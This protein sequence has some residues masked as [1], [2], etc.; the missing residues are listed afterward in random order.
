MLDELVKC[1]GVTVHVSFREFDELLGDEHGC[2]WHIGHRAPD[3]H[4]EISVNLASDRLRLEELS[5]P[6]FTGPELK[7]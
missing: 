1:P 6:V 4:F 5:I 7:P 3:H 2:D